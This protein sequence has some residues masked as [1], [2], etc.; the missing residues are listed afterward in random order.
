MNLT[1]AIELLEEQLDKYGN[2]ELRDY[3]N[4]DYTIEKFAYRETDESE[5]VYMYFKEVE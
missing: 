5:F 4:E 2:V 1:Q 3:D